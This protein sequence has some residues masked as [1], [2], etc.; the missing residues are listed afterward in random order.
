M[1]VRRDYGPHGRTC[2]Q[3]ALAR[4]WTSIDAFAAYLS[5]QGCD[6]HRTA[7]DQWARGASH[8]P[9]DVLR[10]LL[11]HVSSEAAGELAGLFLAGLDLGS[12]RLAVTVEQVQEVAP[13]SATLQAMLKASELA[14]QGAQALSDGQVDADEAERLS[15]LVAG[16]RGRLAE[17]ERGLESVKRPASGR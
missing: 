3:V 16:L 17:L 14:A 1:K 12:C 7:V 6:V 11:E 5:A 13:V 10:L 15:A 2:L 8:M 9:A 4:G